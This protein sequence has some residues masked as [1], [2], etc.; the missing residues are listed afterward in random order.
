MRK[1]LRILFFKFLG[2]IDEERPIFFSF[3][4]LFSSARKQTP[5]MGIH[6]GREGNDGDLL[7]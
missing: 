5:F 2:E 6:W 4:Y 7:R 1:T 3:F